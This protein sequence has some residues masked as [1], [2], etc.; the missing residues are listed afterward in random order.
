MAFIATL[1]AVPAR[2]STS[3]ATGTSFALVGVG[4]LLLPLVPHIGEDINGARLW[5]HVGPLSFQPE[6]FAKLAL[7]IFFA[8]VLV[9]RADLL[10]TGTRRIGRWLV[11][12]PRYLAPL[13]AA[14]GVSLLVLLAENDLGSSFLFFALFVGML[15]VATGRAAYLALGAGLFA[16][17]PCSPSRSIHH[18]Q[19]RVQA[20][21]DPWAHFATS[22]YQIIEGWF[23]LGG[24][25]DVGRWGRARG[26]PGSSPRPPPT[27]YSRRS[28][29]SSAWSVSPPS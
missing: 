23:A 5:V 9:E 3:S 28:A 19:T 6:E 24:R 7:A 20:W 11:L 13:L 1:A 26:T 21:L 16:P 17:A 8:S 29:R 2:P 10:A 22:G 4:L 12:D 14:W 15:W 25:G 18:A 27:S